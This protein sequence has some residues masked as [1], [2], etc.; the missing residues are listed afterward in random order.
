M[1]R[2]LQPNTSQTQPVFRAANPASLAILGIASAAARDARQ[3]VADF[4]SKHSVDDCDMPVLRVAQHRPIA[5]WTEERALACDLELN[6]QKRTGEY[7]AR[8]SG[9]R[10]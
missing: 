8:R 1:E 4:R 2:T 5:L 3:H 9:A 6:R 7:D 10:A